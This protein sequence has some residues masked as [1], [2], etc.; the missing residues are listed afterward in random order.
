MSKKLS[1]PKQVVKAKKETAKKVE[2]VYETKPITEDNICWAI[3]KIGKEASVNSIRKHL[4]QPVFLQLAPKPVWAADQIRAI[5][6]TLAKDGKVQ[7]IGD[8][9]PRV[10]KIA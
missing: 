10:Y 7:R 8:K 3:S 1:K 2:T 5:L 4:G 6:T 9:T